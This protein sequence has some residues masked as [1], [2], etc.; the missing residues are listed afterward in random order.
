M[1]GNKLP[2]GNLT[3]IEN[4]RSVW[5]HEAYNFTK[6][7]ASDENLDLLSISL[8]FDPGTLELEGTEVAVGPYAADIV[9]RD[10]SSPEL[11]HVVIENQF[12]KLNHDHLGKTLTYGGSLQ[13]ETI[14]IVAEEFGEEH[15]AALEWLNKISEPTYKFFGVVIELWQIGDSLPAPKFEVVVKPDNWER[16][17]RASANQHTDKALKPGQV[18]HLAYWRAF[19]EYAKAHHGDLKL[20]RQ[21]TASPYFGM[22]IN[23]SNFELN[24]ARD[25]WN[26]AIRV[27]LTMYGKEAKKALIKLQKEQAEIEAEIGYPL[28]W[29][30]SEERTQQYVRIYWSDVDPSAEE[31]WNNQFDWICTKLK[32]FNAVLGPRVR[33]LDLSDLREGNT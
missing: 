28:A 15:R 20:S 27:E 18:E 29:D 31:I 32:D 2:L 25:T 11:A 24:A 17:L 26:N 30:L 22:S 14:I 19:H 9:C 12:G 7:L 1:N 5:P 8:G 13:A 4:I 33:A 6:W 3:R 16:Q 10:A 21:P 23:R